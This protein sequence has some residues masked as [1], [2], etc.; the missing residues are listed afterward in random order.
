MDEEVKKRSCLA[1]DFYHAAI[2][3]CSM[4]PDKKDAQERTYEYLMDALADD[5]LTPSAF[6]KL[7]AFALLDV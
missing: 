2:A 7:A 6:V 4:L 5:D 1:Y 3:L